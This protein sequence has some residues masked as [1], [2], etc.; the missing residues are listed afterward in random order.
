M[1]TGQFTESNRGDQGPYWNHTS[2]RSNYKF[3]QKWSVD[4]RTPGRPWQKHLAKTMNGSNLFYEERILSAGRSRKLG[5][6]Q[7]L[8]AQHKLLCQIQRLSMVLRYLQNKMLDPTSAN[9]TAWGLLQ[10]KKNIYFGSSNPEKK[11][12]ST[13]I[14]CIP[15]RY[16]GVCSH[17]NMETRVWILDHQW[18]DSWRWKVEKFRWG[19]PETYSSVKVNLT[20]VLMGKMSSKLTLN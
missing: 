6:S 16:E 5:T 9:K 19:S 11:E 3:N 2:A 13:S 18:C 12:N 8:R 17:K 14:N 1:N 20:Q 4:A 10:I 15:R 7:I